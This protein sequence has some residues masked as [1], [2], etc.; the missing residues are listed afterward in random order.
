MA[1]LWCSVRT[2]DV[3]GL[4]FGTVLG[5]LGLRDHFAHA[6]GLA[7][8]LHRELPYRQFS[9]TRLPLYVVAAD[10]QTGEEEF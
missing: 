3:L 2:R 1:A 5:L 9:E 4:S 10:Q 7:Q 8:L 6:R